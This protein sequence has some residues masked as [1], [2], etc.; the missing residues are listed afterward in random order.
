MM[1]THTTMNFHTLM[2]I[3]FVKHQGDL[4]YET[5][6]LTIVVIVVKLFPKGKIYVDLMC[7]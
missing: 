3:F 7:I 2:L 5:M 1:N 4:C 6:K